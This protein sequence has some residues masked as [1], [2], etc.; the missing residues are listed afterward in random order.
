[1][2]EADGKLQPSL[3]VVIP[4][5]G[6]DVAWR[7]Q[8]EMEL[9]HWRSSILA[10]HAQP[11]YRHRLVVLSRFENRL[12]QYLQLAC[13]HEFPDADQLKYYKMPPGT[14]VNLASLPVQH[15]LRKD[16]TAIL[17]GTDAY[18]AA[19]QSYDGVANNM[20]WSQRRVAL[21]SLQGLS[22]C[23]S[24]WGFKCECIAPFSIHYFSIAPLLRIATSSS[25]PM[26]TLI[27]P[28]SP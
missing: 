12:P 21:T 20:Y 18:L 5:L 17:G 15:A 24:C 13:I 27:S 22:C 6:R 8:L 3:L 1:M 26:P 7:S 14:P 2:S 25:S 4:G 16:R 10:F 19:N 28:V 23:A 9:G 11:H